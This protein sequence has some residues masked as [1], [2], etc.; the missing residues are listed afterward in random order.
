MK[1]VQLFEEFLNESYNL[2]EGIDFTFLSLDAEMDEIKND[3]QVLKKH[4]FLKWIGAKGAGDIY[5]VGSSNYYDDATGKDGSEFF[6]PK[7]KEKK[8][9]ELQIHSTMSSAGVTQGYYMGQKAIEINDGSQEYYW[10]GPK[11]AKKFDVIRDD[12]LNES[13]NL[14]ENY[15]LKGRDGYTLT[16]KNVRNVDGDI[17]ADATMKF[18]DRKDIK[19]FLNNDLDNFNTTIYNWAE[20]EGIIKSN[21]DY[22][23]GFSKHKV[24]ND[25]IVGKFTFW[26][27]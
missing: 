21:E 27:A 20:K 18:D 6:K 2:N 17:E 10:V 24:K 26:K 25:T 23:L 11:A 15:L 22:S 1:H 7:G 13:Y 3:A 8:I 12:E 16:L 19:P 9:P 14:N 5:L 4:G